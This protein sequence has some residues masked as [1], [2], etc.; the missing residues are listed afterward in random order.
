MNDRR[1]QNIKEYLRQR[2]AQTRI[3]SNIQQAT[4]KMAV[5]ISRAASLFNFS[6]SQLREWEKRGL[7][8]TERP[9]LSPESKSA[10]GKSATGHRQYSLQMV[11]KLAI[12]KDLIDQGYSP[13]DIPLDVD[14]VWREIASSL[15]T[16]PLTSPQL[17]GES[18]KIS[19]LSI[20]ARIENTDKQEFWRYFV[21]QTL[22]LSLL[23]ICDDIP[24]A[25]AGLVLPLEDRKLAGALNH[26]GDLKGIGRALVGWQ[27]QN[28]SFYLFLTDAPTFDFPTDFRLQTL[29]LDAEQG[30]AGDRVLDNTFILLKRETRNLVLEPELREVV[31]RMLILVYQHRSDWEAT[32]DYGARDWLYQA[33]DLER[34]SHATGD[35]IFNELLERVIELGG[36]VDGQ[37]RWHFCALLVPDEANQP[38]QQQNLIVRAQTRRSSYQIGVTR[39]NSQ[40][41]DQTNSITV[42][43]F[44]GS[45]IVSM[46]AGLPGDSMIN[47][48]HLRIITST[49]EMIAQGRPGGF[50]QKPPPGEVLHS[51]LAVP[52]VGDYSI[53]IA[54]FY[55]EA[56][57]INAFSSTDQRVL[58]I[59]S[60][61]IE[62]LM[63]VSS[64]RNQGL[65]K[66]AAFLAN[67]AVVDDTFSDFKVEAD[68]ITT[69]DSLLARIQSK[70]VVWTHRKDE[71]SII[72]VDIDHQS[73]LA[74]KYG[75]RIA[76]NL[77]QQVGLRIRGLVSTI[78]SFELFH[79]SADKYYILLEGMDLDETRS[80]AKQLQKA[81]A[82]GE[83]RIQPLSARPGRAV[84]AA[85]MLEV[86]KVTVHMG[87]STYTLAKLDELL[88]RYAPHTAII[89]VR[90]LILAG[91]DAKLERGKLAGGDC[92]VSWDRGVWDYI[93]LP[94]TEQV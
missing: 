76:R 39:I 24:N 33:H 90:S 55:I 10:E 59:I 82:F 51:A 27:G 54:V 21:T 53:S 34:A 18:S 61:M 11:S 31:R 87:V 91:L 30:L 16:P 58:R 12:I 7:L 92:I 49:S 75:N 86:P 50:F 44:E 81:L 52:V 17:A 79:I 80:L 2:E 25:I 37:D 9:L 70:E 94:Q 46:P 89:Y 69:I 36:Q 6:E 83:Y 62:E 32:L 68:F 57:D 64:A 67:P 40:D 14:Q 66:R 13:G 78:T 29:K 63:M 22:R 19:A 8:Q 85:N 38:V 48:P 77:S 71:L 41:T 35:R 20:D 3:L 74:M 56:R 84:A 47:P 60:R 26:P 65:G 4:S 93:V 1:Q 72:A 88:A 45:Q 28:G 23:L 42:K 15:T 73:D 5:T 43:A